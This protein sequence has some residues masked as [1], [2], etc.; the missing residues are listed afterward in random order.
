MVA[1]S[2]HHPNRIIRSTTSLSFPPPIHLDHRILLLLLHHFL[3]FHPPFHS[4]SL[5]IIICFLRNAANSSFPN[6]C[7]PIKRLHPPFI[8]FPSSRLSPFFGQTILIIP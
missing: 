2:L 7:V 4:H 8:P 1:Y 3:S 5:P 6:S